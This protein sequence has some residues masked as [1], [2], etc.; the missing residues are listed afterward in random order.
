M[1]IVP[2]VPHDDLYI[3]HEI[4]EAPQGGKST[5]SLKLCVP[6]PDAEV[7]T[8]APDIVFHKGSPEAGWHGW[9]TG[10]VILGLINHMEYHQGTPF[11]CEE[12]EE[13]LAHLRAAHAAT[14][15]R[16]SERT[17]RGVQYDHKTP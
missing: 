7:E 5:Y 10:H 6:R 8:T 17:K 3:I 15:K 16:V 11:A 13:I 2:K 1:P 12:N 4:R 14:K 9:T